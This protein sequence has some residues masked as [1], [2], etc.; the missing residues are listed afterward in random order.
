MIISCFRCGKEID[1]PNPTNA[2]YI[3]AE[4][5]VV[6]GVQ[7]TAIICPDCYKPSDFVI[8]GVHKEQG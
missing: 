1:T 5:T 4:D 2:D 3:I 6:D 7:K 8:W